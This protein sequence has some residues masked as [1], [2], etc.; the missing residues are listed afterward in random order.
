ML[1]RVE[2]RYVA[3]VRR[4]RW[5][6]LVVVTLGCFPFLSVIEPLNEDTSGTVRLF[7]QSLKKQIEQT[8]KILG[9]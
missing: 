6:S 9:Q 7:G 5:R 2:R 4:P 3:S 8:R 1:L